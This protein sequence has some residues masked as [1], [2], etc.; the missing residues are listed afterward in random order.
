[1]STGQTRRRGRVTTAEAVRAAALRL[2]A[3]RGYHAT[4]MRDIAAAVG[5]HAGSLYNHVES[6]EDLLFALLTESITDRI[7]A[8][9][10]ATDG[11][12]DPVESFRAAV[13][14]IVC[15]RMAEHR[16][17]VVGQSELRALQPGRREGV[18]ALRDQYEE[19]IG[20]LLD[21]GVAR[22]AF[23]VNDRKLTIYAIIAVAQQVGRWYRPEGRLALEQ[24]SRFY[25]DF[26]LAPI[27]ILRTTD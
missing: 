26:L 21:R 16:E 19:A 27:T 10:D 12:D 1:V 6:K 8:I 2:F 15:H 7:H 9:R 22:G 24:V 3:E 14:V 25:Q 11:L 18:V 5:T 23:R 13:D 20:Q 17:I 4:S